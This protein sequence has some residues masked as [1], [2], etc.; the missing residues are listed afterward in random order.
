MLDGGEEE[1][2]PG[3]SENATRG[4]GSEETGFKVHRLGVGVRV[5]PS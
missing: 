5:P 2:S 1:R 4:K 3:R